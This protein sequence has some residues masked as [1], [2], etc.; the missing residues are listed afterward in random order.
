M[1]GF[2]SVPF[3]W[4]MI[5]E[6]NEPGTKNMHLSLHVML[7]IPELYTTDFRKTPEH[8]I[9]W[10]SVQWQPSCSMRTDERTARHEAKSG[11]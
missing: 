1:R 3:V 7:M 11:F 4:N 10:K 9:S 2:F 8:K 5:L 6:V